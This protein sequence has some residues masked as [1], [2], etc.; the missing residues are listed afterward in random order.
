VAFVDGSHELNN[1]SNLS[2][3]TKLNILVTPVLSYLRGCLCVTLC[4]PGT[5]ISKEIIELL[6][7]WRACMCRLLGGAPRTTEADLWGV[8]MDEGG[9]LVHILASQPP[10]S[11]EG[12]I[13][14]ND[15]AYDSFGRIF[16]HTD[17]LLA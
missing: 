4:A 11:R 17:R 12:T 10:G 2:V 1:E 15:R 7:A 5:S 6:L 14:L 3:Y 16:V 8:W 13:I 9:R